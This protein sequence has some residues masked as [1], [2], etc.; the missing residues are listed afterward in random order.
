MQLVKSFGTEGRKG[1]PLEEFPSQ[2]TVFPYIC[3]R[4]SDVK[5]LVVQ[6]EAPKPPAPSPAPTLQDP[7]IIN[8]GLV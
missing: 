1:N 5:D 4:A 7:A 6:S 8:V 3:F 2:D